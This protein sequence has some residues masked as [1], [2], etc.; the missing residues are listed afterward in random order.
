MG[1]YIKNMEKPKRCDECRFKTC[2][3]KVNLKR[4]TCWLNGEEC[5]KTDCPLIEIDLVK[6]EECEWSNGECSVGER[7]QG[8]CTF[9]ER[10]DEKGEPMEIYD[11]HEGKD[12]VCCNCRHNKRTPKKTYIDCNCDIDGHYI[13]YIQCFDNWCR[14]WAKEES[15]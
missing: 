13:G 4:Y 5:G 10:A 9:G 1:V 11:G 3:V 7:Y 6:C 12:R 15:R 8:G 2:F 14:H